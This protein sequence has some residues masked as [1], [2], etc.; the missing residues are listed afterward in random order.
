MKYRFSDGFMDFLKRAIDNG[1]TGLLSTI[2]SGVN[3]LFWEIGAL[4]NNNSKQK[5]LILND[6]FNSISDNLSP[7]YGDYLNSQNLSLLKLFAEKCTVSAIGQISD[8]IN[9]NYIPHF[10]DLEEEKAWLFYIKLMQSASLSPIELKKEIDAKTIDRTIIDDTKFIDR[11][12]LKSF[13]RNSCQLY[14]GEKEG[15]VFR[16]LFEPAEENGKDISSFISKQSTNEPLMNIYG[17]II[18][19]QAET[20]YVLNMQF[21]MLMWTIGGEI[22]R[23]SERANVSVTECITR[24]VQEFGSYFPSVFNTKELSYCIKLAEQYKKSSAFMDISEMVSWGHIKILLEINDLDK[25]NFIAKK[26]LN[27]GID[28]QQL[29][30]LI[31][32]NLIDFKNVSSVLSTP[33][34]G[35]STTTETSDGNNITSITEHIITP[36]SHPLHD[37]N[38]N[39]YKVPGLLN[40]LTNNTYGLN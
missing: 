35:N 28:V 21:N 36:I 10:F 9:W 32:K 1:Y 26:V 23:L 17:L 37:L 38:R 12:K 22:I 14:F 5:I 29:K 4:L 8:S 20:H 33:I 3:L 40:F 11:T 2:N 31:S 24:C 6:L 18:E 27:E 19:F 16:K 13:Y 39:I 34:K 7:I 15:E 30:L 25:Q